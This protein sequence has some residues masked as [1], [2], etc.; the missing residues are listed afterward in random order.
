VRRALGTAARGL[1]RALDAAA[2]LLLAAVVVITAARVAGRYVLGLPM[3]WSE[4]LTRLLFVWLVMIGAARA[5]HLR[6]D[7]LRERLHG[8]A[9]RWLDGF[10]ALVSVTLL[11]L[12]V[13]Y[14]HALVEL[15]VYDRYTALGVSVQYAYW[16]LVIGA[17]LWIVGVIAELARGRHP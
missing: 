15:T 13:V 7:L 12:L 16:A 6:I 8:P 9:G 11:A 5:A 14:G 3:P 2:A 10:V 17:L 4:E 1:G